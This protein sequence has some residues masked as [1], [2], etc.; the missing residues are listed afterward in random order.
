MLHQCVAPALLWACGTWLLTLEQ[1]GQLR[2]LQNTMIRRMLKFK[3]Q[4]SE[5]LEEFMVR[6]SSIIKRVKASHNVETWDVT[7]LKRVR[8][9]AG[10]VSRMS[11]YAPRRWAVI[12]MGHKDWEHLEKIK[13]FHGNQQHGRCIHVWRFEQQFYRWQFPYDWRLLPTQ[14]DLW[15]QSLE[16]WL[17]WRQSSGGSLGGNRKRL[18][19]N[20]IYT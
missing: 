8:S 17:V 2:G 10:H 1:L 3:K 12:A 5:T 13:F 4:E 20:S 15:D 11:S 6:T 19:E 16:S 9:W 7:A 14:K 18:R